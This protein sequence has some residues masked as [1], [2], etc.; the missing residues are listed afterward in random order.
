MILDDYE[1]EP[2]KSPENRP[3]I[4]IDLFL[5]VFQNHLEILHREYQVIIRKSV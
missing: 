5:R 3:K 4:A 1:W 2:A